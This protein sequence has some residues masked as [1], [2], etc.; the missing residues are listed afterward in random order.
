MTFSAPIFLFCFLPIV[1]IGFFIFPQNWRKGYL[2]AVSCLF[3]GWHSPGNLILLL[4][5]IFLNYLLASLQAKYLRVE[6]ERFAHIIFTVAIT[7]NVIFLGYMKYFGLLLDTFSALGINLPFTEPSSIPLGVSFFVFSAISYQCD[8]FFGKISFS[9]NPMD[10]AF[11][12]LFFPKLLQGP[13]A[14]FKEISKQVTTRSFDGDLIAAG[15]YQ[16]VIGLA[17]KVILA[18]QIS[19]LVNDVFQQSAINLPLSVTWAAAIGYTFQIYFDFSGYSDMAIGLGKIL[20]YQIPQNFNYPYI[21]KTITEFWRRWHITLGAF[22]RDYLFVPL[23]L[24]NRRIKILRFEINTVIVFALTGLWHGARWQFLIWGLW[25]GF[26]IILENSATTKKYL[27]RVPEIIRW[28]ITFLIIIIGWVFFRSPDIGYAM[29][30]IKV[31]F[32]IVN[33]NLSNLNIWWYLDPKMIF[34]LIVGALFIFPIQDVI[35]KRIQFPEIWKK[36]FQ[37]GFFIVLFALSIIQVMSSSIH[38]FI[39]FN[40]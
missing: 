11:F 39:Y 9:K 26:W 19:P 4:L 30:Y 23:E 33:P 3:Y 25:Q 15:C 8:L 31:M 12:I 16:F 14:R 6:S 18:D 10:F 17:K 1:L 29:T 28:G 40:F 5:F 36:I 22:F 37:Y 21:S 20:G 13:I 24:K 27:S 2:L 35:T 32:G 38:S 7:T 34:L